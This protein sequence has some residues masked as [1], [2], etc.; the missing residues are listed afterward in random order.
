MRARPSASRD[1][2]V[3]R[4]VWLLTAVALF[5][6]ACAAGLAVLLLRAIALATNVFYYHRLGL[7]LV[8]PEIGSPSSD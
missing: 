2:A 4:R 8:G 5:M 3:D 6:G 1:F 7:V